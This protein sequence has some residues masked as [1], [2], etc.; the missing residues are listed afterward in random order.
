MPPLG[1]TSAINAVAIS[2]D[3][4]YVLTG[5]KDN[6]AMLWSRSGKLLK[7]LSGHENP[8][9]AVSFA[10]D[11]HM[12]TLE[13]SPDNPLLRIWS[14]TG[15]LL[16]TLESQDKTLPFTYAQFHPD[17]QSVLAGHAG[18]KLQRI[19]W[20][21][22]GAVLQN[23]KGRNIDVFCIA[24]SQNGRRFLVGS[25]DGY[26]SLYDIN[27]SN[28]IAELDG[29]FAAPQGGFYNSVRSVAL[30]ADGQR[31]ITGGSD[32]TTIIWDGN[33]QML[34]KFTGHRDGVNAV[35]VSPD[36]LSFASGGNDM[37]L[38]ILEENG[39]VRQSGVVF[40]FNG[41]AFA[42]DGRHLVGVG[43]HRD[44]II[45][46]T[47]GEL[48]TI[49]AL[50]SRSS[51][52][53]S[54]AFSPDG[55]YGLTGGSGSSIRL[56]P[57]N[58][59]DVQHFYNFSEYNTPVTFVPGKEAVLACEDFYPMQEWGFNRE[60]GPSYENADGNPVS[61]VAYAPDGGHIVTGNR[62]GI[63]NIWASD[64]RLLQQIE[65]H[66]SSIQALQFS[67]DS[68]HFITTSSG[69]QRGSQK[70]YDVE[71]NTITVYELEDNPEPARLWSLDGQLVRTYGRS[72]SLA[73]LSPDGQYVATVEEGKVVIWDADGTKLHQWPSEAFQGGINALTFSPD[74]Q[75]LL[76]GLGNNNAQLHRLDG[77]LLQAFKGH[78]SSV[79]AV[80]FS[81]N[82]RNIITGS[83]DN[84]ARVWE[85]SSG[86][87]LATLMAVG[88]EDWL[89]ISPEGLFD[90][91]PGAMEQL[92][93]V[94]GLEVIALDQLKE[95]YFEPGLLQKLLGNNQEEVRD[96]SAFQEVPLYP[97]IE[98]N[99]EGDELAVKLTPREGGIGK[100]SLFIN[101]KEM[102]E[103]ANPSRQTQFSI[104]L[105]Q[106]QS[107]YLHGQANEV[108]LIAF[109]ESGWLKSQP[110][111]LAY[112]PEEGYIG[113]RGGGD[114]TPAFSFTAQEDAELYFLCVG[115]SNYNGEQLDLKFPDKDAVSMAQAL[116]AAGKQL[117]GASAVHPYLLNTTP[118]P[119]RPAASK[120]N[121]QSALS[122]IA[123][124]AQPKDI[125]V[126]YFSGHGITYGSAE[127]A[128]FYY[129]TKD[130]ASENLS[131]DEIRRLYA[132]SSEEL[133]QWTNDAP[134]LKQV[135]IFDACNSGKVVESLLTGKKTLNS[136]QIRALDR[137]QD[138]T[139]MFVLSGSAAD[140]VSYEASRYG[141][142]LLT[143][144]LLEGMSG[145]A[146]REGQYIDVIT[147]FQYSRD[148][149]PELA[150]TIG[151]IQ[152]PTMAFPGGGQSFDIGIVNEQVNIPVAQVKPVFVRNVFQEETAFDDVLDIGKKLQANL[153][154]ITAKG[155]KASLVYV[156]VPEYQDAYSIKGRYRLE[157]ETVTLKARLF[158][159]SQSLGDIQVQGAN[160][161]LDAL[162][163]EV[164]QQAFAVLQ[165]E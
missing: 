15:E 124:K 103:D 41:L 163:E 104:P 130:I 145:L 88:T 139:G 101:R 74:S 155:A 48:R 99:I 126:M 57:I 52:V 26:A 80:S 105:S 87:T 44:A 10:R 129:L 25:G 58:S 34:G 63:I 31:L 1:H 27:Q 35:A 71:G 114:E 49:G 68:Q 40:N 29:H 118:E 91:S 162:V 141:Q 73:A 121:I 97:E 90:A 6:T 86:K 39:Q 42:P 156:D 23:Y 47:K 146:L 7:V 154:D 159:N 3:G 120:A 92:Y 65:G 137:M 116:E 131:D 70:S 24:V 122:E 38:F 13:Q 69:Q 50:G 109:N 157:G 100:I 106:F 76:L 144:S 45:F 125:L 123:E 66:G 37:A 11:G 21:N 143:Y 150:K 14:P 132:I 96:V 72:A 161:Q 158:R 51:A 151:G 93:Y 89:T 82:G 107:Y 133:I 85:V 147:L 64:G 138:R 36:G 33:G 98:A 30:S 4:L 135:L 160:G 110:Y 112:S 62:G 5:G 113:S 117:F 95:R 54:V 43:L 22:E 81:P 28:P 165:K 140:K 79:G 20:R 108:S 2:A 12:L 119:G 9:Q 164:L 77:G 17:G 32:N 56:W 128:Q 67:P 148:K 115:T 134:A 75:N 46:D 59:R 53:T 94:S 61:V 149:V 83:A 18:G 102:L 60:P 84:T 19:D 16:K 111:R 127:K 136:S 142:G 8:I 55:E 78:K 152:T 153:Q